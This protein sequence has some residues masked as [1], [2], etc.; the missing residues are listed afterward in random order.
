MGARWNISQFHYRNHGSA[1]GRVLCGI[2]LPAADKK[3]FDAFLETLGYNH[4][5]ETTN[6]VYRTFLN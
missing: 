4:W 1:F 2:Q 3:A 5:H 6:P